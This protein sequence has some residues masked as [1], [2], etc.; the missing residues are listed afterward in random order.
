VS[1]RHNPLRLNVGFI[2]HETLGY[3]RDFKFDFPHLEL[4]SDLPVKDFKGTAKFSRTQRCILIEAKLSGTLPSECVRCLDP[5]LNTTTSNFT[6]LYAFD[7]HTETELEL[8]VPE[9][10]YIDLSP[11]VREYLV[12]DT[13]TNPLCNPKCAGLCPLCGIN[14]NKKQCDCKPDD[15]DPRLAK[16]KDL[17]D[18][19]E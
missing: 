8:R 6:E 13:P 14:L 2:I 7:Q 10:G 3:T 18:K 9:D 19:D 16:L 5:I 12:L 17:L 4:S 15:F 11:I 1:K